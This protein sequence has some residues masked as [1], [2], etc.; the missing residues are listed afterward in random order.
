MKTSFRP[1]ISPLFRENLN[2]SLSSIKTNGLRSV[3]TILIIAVGIMALVGILTAIEAIGGSVS[4]SF[5]SL[6][7][8][9]FTIRSR[10][11]SAE[12]GNVRTRIRNTPTI[13]YF[14]ATE[15]VSK[16]HEP[17]WISV[18]TTVLSGATIKYESEKTNPTINVVGVDQNYLM[19]RDMAIHSGRGIA[20]HDVAAGSFVA[21]IGNDIAALFKG[22][23][24]LGAFISI[25]GVRYMVIGLL[26]SQGGG[27]GGG[28]NAQ[29]LIPLSNARANFG[30]A[31]QNY[32]IMVMP[33]NP[34]DQERAIG[35]AEVCF[36]AIRRL[37]PMDT[38][39][40]RIDRANAFMESLNEIMGY[41]KIVAFIIGFITLL[42]AAVGLMN[43]MLVSVNERI[44]EI[45]TRKAMGATAA[46]I[47]Q[48]FLL[49][50]IV[51]GQ[52]GGVLGIVL[53]VLAGNITALAIKIPFVLPWLWIGVGITVCFLVG[54][55]SGYIPAVRASRLDPIEALR[56]E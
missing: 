37:A 51:I 38:M 49:E 9:S 44:R 35:E 24:P 46:T 26:A 43:I 30:T 12:G 21:I 19:I 53:G 32:R 14:Q 34:A 1:I 20:D 10:Y 6:G 8:S 23:D 52:L 55:A 7:A 3:L 50:S 4:D 25:N 56:Y 41:I 13:T 28:P 33:K 18:F 45:G 15:F 40:F 48:Q 31:N 39:D 16:Y 36:R 11:A 42:G 22:K 27:F 47:K 54:V 17:A 2:V 5:R 29:V